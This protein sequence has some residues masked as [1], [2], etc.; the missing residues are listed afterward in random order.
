MNDPQ[1]WTLIGV[2]A[3]VMAGGL[4]LLL[5]QNERIIA[6]LRSELTARFDG[7]EGR[8][9]ARFEAMD[10]RFEAVDARF[11]AIDARLEAIDARFTTM[12]VRLD[13]IERRL[14]DLDGEVAHL[15]R[16]FWGSS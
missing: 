15:A 14:D 7:L 5:R 3:A 13:S 8:M 1:I 11:E 4:T 10:A 12:D 9:D 16:R 2:F 6:S